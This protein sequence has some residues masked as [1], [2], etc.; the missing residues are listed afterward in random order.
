MTTT[1]TAQPKPAAKKTAAQ[2][3]AQEQGEVMLWADI[4]KKYPGQHIVIK[5]PVKTPKNKYCGVYVKGEV[6]CHHKDPKKLTDLFLEKKT[7][8][9]AKCYAFDYI[10]DPKD[11]NKPRPFW[12]L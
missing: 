10:E 1:K 4:V 5:D 3:P 8:C 9:K 6:F 12:I 11:K 2:K 7:T